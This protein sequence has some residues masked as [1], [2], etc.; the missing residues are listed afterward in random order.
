MTTSPESTPEGDFYEREEEMRLFLG[1]VFPGSPEGKKVKVAVS[2]NGRFSPRWIDLTDDEELEALLRQSE[3]HN[4]FICSALFKPDAETYTANDVLT[5]RTV[6]VDIDPP[7]LSEKDEHG[8]KVLDLTKIREHEAQVKKFMIEW[9]KMGA[10][11][12][13]SGSRG[14]RHVRFRVNR[15]LTSA[16][17]EALNRLARDR[18]NGDNKQSPES[19]LRL[20]GTFNH[21]RGK[22][23]PVKTLHRTRG[24]AVSPEELAT[25]LGCQGDF[26]DYVAAGSERHDLAASDGGVKFNTKSGRY[27][28]LM[29]GIEYRN[30]QFEEGDLESRYVCTTGIVKDCI[31]AGLNLDNAIYAARLCKPLVDKD[32]TSQYD[33]VKDVTRVWVKEGGSKAQHR[34][35]E[36]F[37][38]T[39]KA[40]EVPTFPIDALPAKMKAYVLAVSKSYQVPVEYVAG[41]CFTALSIASGRGYRVKKSED[42]KEALII[43]SLFLSGPSTRKS[44]PMDEVLAPIREIQK[45]KR[46]EYHSTAFLR[47]ARG[48]KAEKDLKELEDQNSG[49]VI[50]LDEPSFADMAYIAELEE[51]V[52][53]AEI[54][55]PT[56]IASDVT[57]QKLGA[58]MAAN[59]GMMAVIDDEATYLRNMGGLYSNGQAEVAGPNKAYQEGEWEIARKGS[60]NKIHVNKAFLPTTLAAQPDV[61][62]EIVARSP[63]LLSSGFIARFL[64]CMPR[65]AR[66]GDYDAYQEYSVPNHLK[67]W[68]NVTLRDIYS[69]AE[70]IRGDKRQVVIPLDDKSHELFRVWDDEVKNHL[71]FDPH[72]MPAQENLGKLTGVTL[73]LAG[74]LTILRGGKEISTGEMVSC[75]EVSRYYAKQAVRVIGYLNANHLRKTV[76]AQLPEVQ[77]ELVT[78]VAAAARKNRRLAEIEIFT[79]SKF[80]GIMKGS[81]KGTPYEISADFQKGL[82]PLLIQADVIEET[83]DDRGKTKYQLKGK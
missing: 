58:E 83:E 40:D 39:P 24:K 8:Y 75:I 55:E 67:K 18:Y 62:S 13:H 82:W 37:K 81:L 46:A 68:W 59:N 11:I 78:K 71:M 48:K 30:Q 53:Q 47:R 33:L 12:V 4:V 35:P 7:Q 56:M 31:A 54:P 45:E 49:H 1:W 28:A 44:P 66:A 9:K 38:P 3:T 25:S 72:Y 70:R 36:T 26:A 69:R 23:T 22:K 74:L 52:R 20:P 21:K 60:E 61:V 80:H 2:K 5:S 41:M 34:V 17:I 32:E 15:D 79:P 50:N 19:V 76:A 43:W 63:G 65:T 57:V 77:N 64:L 51:L 6:W 42:W 29:A 14:G 10:L 27:S 16:E 73:R